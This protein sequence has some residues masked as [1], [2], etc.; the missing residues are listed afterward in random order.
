MS[1]LKL[2]PE[3]DLALGQ[4]VADENG[5]LM[6]YS[7]SA[8]LSNGQITTEPLSDSV[9]IRD[10]DT[11]FGYDEKLQWIQSILRT[12]NP[13]W[14]IYPNIGANVSDL[15]GELNSPKTAALG[16]TNI[17]QALTSS[18]YLKATDFEIDS[19]PVSPTKIMYNIRLQRNEQTTYQYNFVLDLEIGVLN[20]YEVEGSR[21]K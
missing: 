4:Q 21:Y 1:D 17:T 19:V 6:Y 14:S 5:N 9:P 7:S 3:G 18:G 16:V 8:Q 13:D 11:V 12:D 15:A 20:Y 2:T 10:V